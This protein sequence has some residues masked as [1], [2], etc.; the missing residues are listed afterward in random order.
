MLSENFNLL[1]VL[2]LFL[3]KVLMKSEVAKAPRACRVA[4]QLGNYQAANTASG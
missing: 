4:V 1:V 3:L 2:V